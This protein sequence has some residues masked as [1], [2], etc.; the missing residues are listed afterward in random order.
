MSDQPTGAGDRTTGRHPDGPSR[1]D[2]VRTTRAAFRGSVGA[3][4]RNIIR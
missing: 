2:T 3:I 1:P 4:L